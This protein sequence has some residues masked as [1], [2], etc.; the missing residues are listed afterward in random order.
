MFSGKKYKNVIFKI[1]KIF[2]AS[3]HIKIYVTFSKNR[4]IVND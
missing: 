3:Q 1:L 4:I 2:K